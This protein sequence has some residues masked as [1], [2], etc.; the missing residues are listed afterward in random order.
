[1]EMTQYTQPLLLHGALPLWFLIVA[2]FIPRIALFAA[3]LQGNLVPFHL[4]GWIPLVLGIVVPRIL[5][6]VL[7][8]RDQGLSVW[9]L[10]HAIVM[11]AVWGGIGGKQARRRRRDEF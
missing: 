7:I 9:F 4:F 6:L 2:L 1:M 11:V 5:V 8:Y 10:I 3:W